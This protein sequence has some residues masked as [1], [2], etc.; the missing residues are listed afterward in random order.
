MISSPI[1]FWRPLLGLALIGA[2]LAEEDPSPGETEFQRVLSSFGQINTIA[3]NGAADNC[4]DWNS[5]T[6]E[7]GQ[8]TGAD[9]SR[10]HMAQAD[11]AG[12]VYIADKEGH[13][14]RL[15]KPDGTI[16]TIAGSGV[17]GNGGEGVATS[18]ALREPNGLYTF[19]DGTT[20]ILETDDECD[21]GPIAGGKIRRL[22]TDGMLT[23]VIDDPELLAGRGLWVS[24]DES[25][26]Y[27]CSWKTV[28]KWTASGGLETFASGF[29][30][31]GPEGLGNLDIDPLTGL[32]CVTDRADHVVYRLSADGSTRTVIAGN[33]NQ[34]SGIEGGLAT[35]SPLD[36]VRGI[37]FRPDGSFFVCTHKGDHAVWFID[38]AGRIWKFIDGDN[39]AHF[40]DGISIGQRLPNMISEP[41]AVTI[42]P[43]G[44][45]LITENDDGYI[46]RITNLCI[47]PVI[48]EVKRE[49]GSLTIT[50]TS[51]R[52]GSYRVEESRDLRAWTPALDV[53]TG[54]GPT[55]TVTVGTGDDHGF[56]RVVQD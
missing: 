1:H 22:G 31:L 7:G 20:Y 44:D 5:A 47:E 36:Q 15:V 13:A 54:N 37:A 4:N 18:I 55:T 32:V 42:A 26:I 51:Q 56:V 50:W 39:K 28:K 9:L 27:Y 19:P 8:A 45:L 10:P 49:P 25:L 48:S 6:M 41:R 17:R 35:N 34:G 21:V 16:H 29:G 3:G 12:N 23:T 52:E 53:E 30:L 2:A 46:R 33:G 24:P 43:N 11:A 14:I 40:G 38:T